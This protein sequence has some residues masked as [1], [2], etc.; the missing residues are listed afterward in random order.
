MENPAVFL[1]PDIKG[2]LNNVNQYYSSHYIYCYFE[3]YNHSSQNMLFI[4]ECNCVII[5]VL[6]LINKLVLNFPV[7]ICNME[8]TDRYNLHK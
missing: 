6:K 4:L 7:L 5:V 1:K 8:N 3:K 2:I